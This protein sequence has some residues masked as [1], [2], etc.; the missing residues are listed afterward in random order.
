MRRLLRY[1]AAY[2]AARLLRHHRRFLADVAVLQHRK[3][4]PHCAAPG[5][6]EM[7]EWIEVV[8][9]AD[10]ACDAIHLRNG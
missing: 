6:I 10:H 1:T 9:R 2:A 8:G 3:A 4:T 7:A 5:R